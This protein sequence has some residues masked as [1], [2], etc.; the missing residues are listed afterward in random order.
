MAT[1]PSGVLGPILGTV[2]VTGPGGGVWQAGQFVEGWCIGSA[3]HSLLGQQ[4]ALLRPA[5]NPPPT[6]GPSQVLWNVA[7]AP[8]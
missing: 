2:S 8:L 6:S 1:D 3:T 7:Y 4:A 5:H